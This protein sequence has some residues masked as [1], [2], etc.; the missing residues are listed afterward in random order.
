[1]QAFVK[2]LKYSA[3]HAIPCMLCVA[4]SLA[5]RPPSALAN[6]AFLLQPD[7]KGEKIVFVARGDIWATSG[8]EG[9]V[10][11]NVTKSFVAES[12]PKISRD[13]SWIA[14][15]HPLDGVMVVPFAGGDAKQLT[16]KGDRGDV[17]GWT[18][19]GQIA[20]AG[21]ESAPF[22][23]SKGLSFVR[24][25]GGQPRHTGVSEIGHA[26][27]DPNGIDM[28]YS[29]SPV[30][31]GTYAKFH[32]GKA[33]QMLRLNMVSGKM[34]KLFPSKWARHAGVLARGNAYFVGTEGEPA[35]NLWS[36]DA[37][38]RERLTDFAIDGVRNLCS[39]GEHLVLEKSGNLC[40]YKLESRL[41][42][43][44][45]IV[46]K[47]MESLPSHVSVPIKST[48]TEVEPSPDGN[49]VALVARGEVFVS[50]NGTVRNISDHSG[51]NDS[52]AVWS[53]DGKLLAFV[54]DRNREN[55]I[56]IWN[57][58]SKQVRLLAGLARMPS[59]IKWSPNSDGI[60]YL[61]DR[62]SVHWVDLDTGRDEPIASVPRWV[63][64]HSAS[65][66]GRLLAITAAMENK[67]TSVIL[68]D[69]ISR[70]S[71][72][73][74]DP[75]FID[76]SCSFDTTENVLYFLSRRNGR[77]DLDREQPVLNLSGGM[78][79]ACIDLRDLATLNSPSH[80]RSKTR[81]I[82]TAGK[83]IDYLSSHPKGVLASGDA[84]CFL[85]DRSKSCLIELSRKTGH[86]F[87][88]PYGS[89]QAIVHDGVLEVWPNAEPETS[90][91]FIS[92][93][94]H[95]KID[96]RKE[97]ESIYW[98]VHRF[99]R[100]QFYDKGMLGV[101]WRDVGEHY[102]AYLPRVQTREDLTIVLTRMIGELPG[103]HNGVSS[104]SVPQLNPAKPRAPES[105]MIVGWDGE[106]TKILRVLRG[107][108]DMQMFGSLESGV[109]GKVKEGQYIHSVN[110]RN[111]T[112]AIGFDELSVG[113]KPDEPVHLEISEF[114]KGPVRLVEVRFLGNYLGYTDFLD[115]TVEQVEKLSGGRLGYAHIF[116][117]YSQGG[118][119]FSDGFYSQWHLDG[120]I[121]DARWN[122][123]GNS[124]PGFI[125]AM[126]ARALFEEVKRYGESSIDTPTMAGPI[127]MLVNQESVSGGDLL[128][129]AFMARRIGTL[130]GNRTAGRTIGNQWYGQLIDG[131]IVRTSEARNLL[132]PTKLD[133]GENQGVKPDIE[134]DMIPSLSFSVHD[135]QLERCIQTL[136]AKLPK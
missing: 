81:W 49:E 122:R 64:S 79:L 87:H 98:S 10:A 58:A 11:R 52:M 48:I 43:P 17:F 24:P 119:T 68:I 115:R 36:I 4:A 3:V 22:P 47:E 62:Q 37:N 110:G 136:L 5:M 13:G 78:S 61:L 125:D 89:S 34:D 127:A 15:N 130:M 2:L 74:T 105:G 121:L 76:T 71:F 19:D 29:K 60:F 54:S 86:E 65:P 77:P 32:G 72:R 12:H 70:K 33:N 124:N 107:R 96:L 112:E 50:E 83:D 31:T 25:T 99:Y 135:E 88:S 80:F 6:E 21:D 28:I 95:F 128:A 26:W 9:W 113:I 40:W 41:L 59:W 91:K 100:D 104:P 134:V 51:A 23:D 75:R 39:D 84:G 93:E 101:H 63:T 97:W 126:Q 85:W 57:K 30:S 45:P 53:K 109:E 132:W 102:A 131:S 73:V 82:D 123:G 116:D 8:Q 46:L 94:D 56:W 69:R 117:T 38:V 67:R 118:G 111:I 42:V 1:M 90:R 66:D 129:S 20:Y 108:T 133:A 114:A 44:I 103:G 120:F 18:M 7:V 14:Y 16:F 35:L 106:G 55:E 92:L 27:F